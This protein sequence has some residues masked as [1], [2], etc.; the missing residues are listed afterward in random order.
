MNFSDILERKF[1]WPKLGDRLLKASPHKGADFSGD[2]WS[3]HVFIWSGY[4]QAADILVRQTRDPHQHVLIYPI[5]FMYRHGL[6]LAMK[7]IIEQYGRFVGIYIE[8]QER[9]H[10]LWALW[11]KT[12]DVIEKLGSG[13]GDDDEAL[14]VVERIV[15]DFHDLD[16][17]NIAFRYP[18]NK[19]G[20]I[21]NLPKS[22]IDLENIR[23]VMEGV[24]GFFSG[25]DGQLDANASA[26]DWNP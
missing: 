17:A 4:M 10:A 16:K 3:R 26:V 13:G 8:E 7:W 20:E 22:S 9:N 21:I 19:N 1:R 18:T 11:L 2:A 14:K 6:E 24:D 5:L 23:D 25:V 15:K 12:K